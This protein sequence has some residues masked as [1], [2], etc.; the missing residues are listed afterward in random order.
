MKLS[1]KNIP[2]LVVILPLVSIILL[3]I[4]ITSYFTKHVD[5]YAQG[6]R[7]QILEQ[8]IARENAKSIDFNRKIIALF[9][10]EE[11]HLEEHIKE[12][13]KERVDM[14]FETASYIYDKYHARGNDAK[15][16]QHIQDALRR[17]VWDDRS[18]YLWITDY[19]G[20]NIMADN[21]E[22]DG[23]ELADFTDA[24]GRAI[25]LEEIQMA[26][27]HGSGFLKSN[28]HTKTDERVLYVKDFK[29]FDW[30]FG[31]GV[32][33][34][35]ERSRLKEEMMKILKSVRTDA[36][37]F[38]AVYDANGPVYISE[39]ARPYLDDGA[40]KRLVGELKPVSQEHRLY[41]GDVM[42]STAYFEPFGWYILRGFDTR[43]TQ[44]IIQESQQKLQE[45]VDRRMRVVMIVSGLL[46]LVVA[47]IAVWFA[48]RINKI[49]KFYRSEVKSR[50]DSLESLNR[51]LEERVRTE[52]KARQDKEHM[53]IQQSKMAAMGDMISLIAHQWR[54]PLNQMSYLLMNIEGAYEHNELNKAY[55]EKKVAEGTDL[56]EFMSHTIED[57][58]NYFIPDRERVE[59]SIAEVVDHSGA[60]IIK[61]LEARHI[62]FETIHHSYSEVK[63]YRNELI[64]VMMNLT[65]NAKDVLVDRKRTDPKIT[66]KT[67]E[68]ETNIIIEVCDNGGGVD[69]AIAKKIFEPY[70][71][72]KERSSGT[73]LGLSMS[74]N[75]VQEHLNGT[76]VLENRDE[77]AC[78]IVTIAKIQ[79]DASS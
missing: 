38:I 55:L 5:D 70:F 9:T 23:K 59:T 20:K 31:G 40:Q 50:Q 54:Q 66:V 57:F 25:I 33:V 22:L 36:S 77:G 58:R 37:A 30:F 1:E 39:G 11:E 26:R 21:P 76:L 32:T 29:H 49:F 71:T 75:I 10:F 6:E 73:G 12:E 34:D 60:L 53:L 35:I 44:D 24:D 69:E 43:S 18:D 3:T 47:L 27:K 51:S 65:K 7:Q 67:S 17:M 41:D 72:T 52:V 42:I 63:I 2:R 15:I 62:E 45:E 19:T 13:L 79:S 8:Y 74:R 16:K 64:Q 78:F 4:V 46:A 48:G 56:L 28:F 14:A 68:N 61:S